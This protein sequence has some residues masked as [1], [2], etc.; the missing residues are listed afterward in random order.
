LISIASFMLF[1]MPMN[2]E[3]TRGLLFVFSCAI[4]YSMLVVFIPSRN[5]VTTARSAT[6]S[7]A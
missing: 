7:S 5:G 4:T 1:A 3:S 2:S 6:D